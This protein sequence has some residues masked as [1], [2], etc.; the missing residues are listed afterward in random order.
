MTQPG[1]IAWTA[2]MLTTVLALFAL[3]GCIKVNADLTL[4]DVDTVS[5]TVTIGYTAKAL[6]L[7]GALDGST[8]DQFLTEERQYLQSIDL[9]AGQVWV[10]PWQ[11]GAYE[12]HIITFQRASIDA[13]HKALPYVTYSIRQDD[14]DYS[15]SG[16]LDLSDI[17]DLD[18]SEAP[19]LRDEYMGISVAIA[20]TMPGS[21]TEA[22]GTIS[23]NTISWTGQAGQVI[24]FSAKSTTGNSPMGW[25]GARGI[26]ALCVLAAVGLSTLIAKRKKNKTK[27]GS[28]PP[29]ELPGYPAGDTGTVQ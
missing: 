14:Q 1:P 16:N 22:N 12:G 7:L 15:L 13:V 20:L 27:A 8:K 4:H 19:E 17:G 28:S 18:Y 2:R 24:E 26:I 10:E 21:V 23:G 11:E 5:G 3:A 25:L 29:V 9:P 6:D